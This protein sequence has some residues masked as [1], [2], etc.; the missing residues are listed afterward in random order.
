MSI[1]ATVS[2]NIYITSLDQLY[3]LI[4][5]HRELLDMNQSFASFHD[6]MYDYYYG[7]QCAEDVNLRL[8]KDEYQI[9]SESV[10][11]CNVLLN[12]FSCDNIKFTTI[13]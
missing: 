11:C 13:E 5:T 9:I 4:D 10:D 3:K 7:C 1:K 12:H 2:K 8:A 6:F